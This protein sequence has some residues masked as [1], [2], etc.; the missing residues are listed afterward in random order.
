M[1]EVGDEHTLE[2]ILSGNE[3]IAEHNREHFDQSS[4]FV[5]NL[6]SA[7]GA[8]KTTLLTKTIPSLDSARCTVIEGDMVGELDVERLR[9]KGI[10]A[11]QISTGRSCHLTADMIARLLHQSDVLTEKKYLFIENVGNLV[12]PAEFVLGEHK[13]VVLL[14][15][16]E[17]ADKPLKY[18]VI[19]RNCDAVVFTKCD[20]L[21]YV[22]FDLNQASQFVA[23][24]NPAANIFAVST[25]TGQGMRE[26]LEW[27][28]NEQSKFAEEKESHVHIHSR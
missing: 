21:P 5:L 2:R 12:C 18:P 27:L 9:R 13:R 11:R 8:G 22:D 4:V 24:I 17:G 25:E 19:F 7:P 23:D 14:S 20:L 6:M 26:W 10:E 28:Q 15:V 1:H 3:E 16:T